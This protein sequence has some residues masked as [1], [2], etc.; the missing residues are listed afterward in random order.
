MKA[1]F[2]LA[3]LLLLSPTLRAPASELTFGVAKGTKIT[4]TFESGM[5]LELSDLNVKVGGNEIPKEQLEGAME[6]TMTI[7]ETL[8]LVD[9]YG[10]LEN[11]LP[12]KVVR[13]FEKAQ[14]E[15]R[16]HQSQ[17]GG[18]AKDENKDKTSELEGKQVVFTL[19]DGEYKAAYVEEGGDVELLEK[20]EEDTD[21][22]DILP[23]KSVSPGDTWKLETRKVLDALS[24]GGSNGYKKDDD[25]D[26]SDE[27][28]DENFKGETEA[29]FKEIREVDG[30]KCAVIT[31][32]ITGE[33]SAP[34][35]MEEQE[36][37]MT[38]EVELEGEVLWDIEAKHFH[39]FDLQGEATM[40]VEFTQEVDA[41]GQPMEL[42]IK[43]EMKGAMVSKGTASE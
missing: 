32:E 7:K 28:I 22:R 14:R 23:G 18:E 24:P 38:L 34:A 9:E 31:L 15:H 16:E 8:E 17:A 2:A 6:L 40:T 42:E 30:R 11:G 3:P 1:L 29:T 13:K 33:S 10:T 19:K 20:L 27:K 25:D 35:K 39:S 41:G 5:D 12:A 36:A 21:L 43:V 26:G 37:T 4:K